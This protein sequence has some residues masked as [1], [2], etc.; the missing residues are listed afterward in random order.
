MEISKKE[1]KFMAEVIGI[2]FS[3]G[4]VDGMNFERRCNGEDEIKKGEFGTLEISDIIKGSIN[5][6][7][8]QIK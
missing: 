6:L 5:K 2:G 4:F 8:N 3:S 1:K 7:I